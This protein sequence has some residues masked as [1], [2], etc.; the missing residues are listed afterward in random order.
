MLAA[1]AVLLIV[2]AIGFLFEFPAGED[3]SQPR[4]EPRVCPA[5][6]VEMRRLGTTPSTRWQLAC[7]QCGQEYR[8]RFDGTLIKEPAR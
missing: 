8:E 5:C 6:N 7:P 2:F 4:P 3:L 1:I